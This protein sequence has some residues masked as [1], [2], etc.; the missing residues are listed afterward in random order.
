MAGRF[1]IIREDEKA[2]FLQVEEGMIRFSFLAPYSQ[3]SN[4]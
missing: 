1:R 4:V 3:V 2:G